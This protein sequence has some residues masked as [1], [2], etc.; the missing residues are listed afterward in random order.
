MLSFV[1]FLA[2]PISIALALEDAYISKLQADGFQQ[3][4]SGCEVEMLDS[5]SK[6][7]HRLRIWRPWLQARWAGRL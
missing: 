5:R 2:A 4:H 7:P 6:R 1:H 3:G